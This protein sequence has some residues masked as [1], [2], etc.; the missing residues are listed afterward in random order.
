[1]KKLAILPAFLVLLAGAT[2]CDKTNVAPEPSTVAAADGAL[3]SLT[4]GKAVTS[5]TNGSYIYNYDVMEDGRTV[6][7]Q[8]TGTFT[9]A[10]KITSFEV[11][12]G[13]ITAMGTLSATN[14]SGPSA[15]FGPV[16]VQVPLQLSQISSSCSLTTVN[17]GSMPVT[18]NGKAETVSFTLQVTPTMSNKNL[19]GNLMCSLSRILGNPSSADTGGVVSHL[20]KI[21]SEIGS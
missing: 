15:N 11:Q 3:N 20:N 7:K 10:L 6:T 1:M 12:N 2:S 17:Y 19:L 4:K 5:N 21:I 18:I 14:V 16:A 8:A 9:S 13:V